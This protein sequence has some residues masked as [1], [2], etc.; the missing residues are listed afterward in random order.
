MLSLIELMLIVSFINVPFGYWRC[1]TDKFSKQWM[2]AVHM[3]VPLVFLLRMLS[4]FGWKEIPLLMLSFAAGQFIGGN[5]K[6][7]LDL[8]PVSGGFIK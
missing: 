5:I 2:M 7:F 4:G 6:K 8:H 1:K 3:P